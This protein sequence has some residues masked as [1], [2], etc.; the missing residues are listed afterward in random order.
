M[1]RKKNQLVPFE[2]RII[3]AAKVLDETGDKNFYGIQIAKLI[4]LA[5]YKNLITTGVLYR[6][7]NRLENM[8]YLKSRWEDKD[9]KNHRPIR[10]Y[11]SLTNKV[12]EGK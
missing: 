5:D 3:L 12:F 2:N 7:L 4:K 1:R 11:Y 9:E 6:A 8:G 10:R